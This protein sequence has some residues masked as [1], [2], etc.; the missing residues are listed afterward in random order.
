ML[1]VLSRKRWLIGNGRMV[2]VSSIAWVSN[3]LLDRW[4]TLVNME[5]VVVGRVCD[6]FSLWEAKMEHH[7]VTHLFGDQLAKQILALLIHI[8][9]YQ[10][11]RVWRS[12]YGTKPS[13]R[14]LYDLYKR[15]PPRRPEATWVWKL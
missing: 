11:V 8:L 10:D 7:L 14:D 13:S 2:Y 3:L 12:T 6:L 5:E 4:P 9:E 1:E 15:E